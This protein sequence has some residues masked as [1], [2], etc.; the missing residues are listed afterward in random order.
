MK[1]KSLFISALSAAV[2]LAGCGVSNND[3]GE[4]V[5]T[6]FNYTISGSVIDGPVKQA[7]V[8]ADLNYNGVCDTGE[9]SALTDE[10]GSF[11][12]KMSGLPKKQFVAVIAKDGNDTYTDGAN[13]ITFKTI[14]TMNEQFNPETN[15]TDLV[16]EN[17]VMD[18][19]TNVLYEKIK[20]LYANGT[21]T[22]EDI[23]KE[24][25]YLSAMLNFPDDN[26]NPGDFRYFNP[27][28]NKT[29]YAKEVLIA[30]GI[31]ENALDSDVYMDDNASDSVKFSDLFKNDGLKYL[32][33]NV[34]L[35]INGKTPQGIEKAAVLYLRFPE[36]FSLSDIGVMNDEAVNSKWD[37]MKKVIA[38]QD[39]V[40][41][42]FKVDD[43][44]IGTKKFYDLDGDGFKTVYNTSDHTFIKYEYSDI[45]TT[46]KLFQSVE[47][48][49]NT[50]YGLINSALYG[51][52]KT[53]V[54]ALGEGDTYG[55]Y[56]Y[57]HKTAL[58]DTDIT[59]GKMYITDST[60]TESDLVNIFGFKTLP[61]QFD[62]EHIVNSTIEDGTKDLSVTFLNDQNAS[63]SLNN[64]EITFL[65]SYGYN[66]DN[67]EIV[68]NV[69]PS[70]D[71]NTS[72]PEYSKYNQNVPFDEIVIGMTNL[73][74]T[75]KGVAAFYDTQNDELL[76][77]KFYPSLTQS[78]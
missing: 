43:A 50:S 23:K 19:F 30:E 39:A 44:F 42:F 8:C 65:T 47:G 60:P 33:D 51:E 45:K 3:E 12:L 67:N 20:A 35:L 64:K 21:L 13:N 46:G 61:I 77:L 78:Y 31:K 37:E 66:A 71:V 28:N 48:E 36:T 41:G 6:E 70:E 58:D 73:V 15:L 63:V 27:L 24:S 29:A 59:K 9:P 26:I 56:Q 62:K 16:S 69:Y 53:D 75:Y 11:T 17:N 18:G 55:V 74:G 34:S 25:D 1:R 38:L 57:A 68:L 40:P 5:Q 49:Y 76:K 4:N 52:N 72:D 10:N 22:N 14:V 32:A 2:L 7:K 54:Y